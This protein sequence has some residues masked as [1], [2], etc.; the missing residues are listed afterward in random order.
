[1]GHLNIVNSDTIKDIFLTG[2][3]STKGSLKNQIIKTVSD[4]FS[5]VLATRKGDYVFPW[6][7]KGNDNDQIG[8]RYIL[9][10]AGP[11]IYVCGD[12]YPIKIPIE[13][14]INS[15]SQSLKESDALDLFRNEI[16]W[17]AI[18]KK[19]LGRGRSITHQTLFED[20]L[21]IRLIEEKNKYR[22]ESITITRKNYT[23]YIPISIDLKNNFQKDFEK[24]IRILN[25]KE[26]I[27][28]IDLNQ[29]PWL[30]DCNFSYEKT[31]E[32][33]LM[34][35]I[36]KQKCEKIWSLL[37][38]SNPN[39]LW[40]GNYLPFGVAGSNIDCVALVKDNDD[41]YTVVV[42]LKKTKLNLKDY[43]LVANQ[44]WDYVLFIKKAFSSFSK[45]HPF[46]V[47]PVILSHCSNNIRA[48]QIVFTDG[49][50]IQWLGYKIDDGI[51]SFK[52]QIE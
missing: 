36:D 21:L 39:I 18:G 50:A 20:E 12:E 30:K 29:I 14:T 42:E 17:N 25:E 9:K 10:I 6:I 31:F 1:M 4:L 52:N 7:I 40:F 13:D 33:W 45:M 19:S 24:N 47:L 2:Y 16:L 41:Y 48:N 28:S 8:F 5:D 49:V 38:F 35:N 3:I 22:A 44:V 34:E 46:K 26:R 43:Q 23:D 27:S 37:G 32:A 51:V 15:Y 11:P